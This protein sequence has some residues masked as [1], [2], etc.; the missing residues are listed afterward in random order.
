MAQNGKLELELLDV[1]GQFL[2][3][4]VDVI[5]RHRVLSHFVRKNVKASGKFIIPN[6]HADPQGLYF[7][8]IA[9]LSY[10]P[11]DDFIG[12]KGSGTTTYQAMFPVNPKKV[13]G[14][15]FP[16]YNKLPND[17]QTLL[18]KSDKV[19]AFEGKT[20]EALYDAL[21]NENLKRAGLLNILAKTNVTRLSNG[22]TVLSYLQDLRELR[23]DRFF[24]VT[25]KELREETKN[26]IA[27]GLFHEA[28][29]SLH[30]LPAQ[31]SGFTPAGSFKTGDRYGNLQLTFFMKGDECVAD[32]DIDDASGL[33]HFFQVLNNMLPGNSTHPYTIH[34]I[35]IAFQKIDPGYRFIL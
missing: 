10:M 11:K 34:Q 6:L 17:G 27:D 33:E 22:R 30:H 31:F 1:Y 21:E 2:N 26:S 32:I 12:I 19:L 25:S 8:D 13:M 18:G 28:D 5:L 23:G 9:P 15:T 29:Q 3:E 35:L 20:G 14:V 24:V 4:K 16:K 7:L